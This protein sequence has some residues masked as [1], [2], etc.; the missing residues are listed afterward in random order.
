MAEKIEV[1]KTSAFQKIFAQSKCNDAP[2]FGEHLPRWPIKWPE[3]SWLRDRLNIV[4]E[5][6]ANDR[7]N[8][9]TVRSKV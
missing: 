4:R 1:D 6:E 2:Y 3:K 8:L 5:R 7:A 9:S